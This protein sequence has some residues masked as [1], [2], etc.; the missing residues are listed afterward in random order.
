M[1]DG[2]GLSLAALV[3]SPLRSESNHFFGRGFESLVVEGFGS[4]FII[5]NSPLNHGGWGGIRTL[6]DV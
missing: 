5:H 6:G 3:T 2:E 1:A 4:S